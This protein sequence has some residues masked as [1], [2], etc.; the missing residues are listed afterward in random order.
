MG[1]EYMSTLCI[2]NAIDDKLLSSNYVNALSNAIWTPL[3]NIAY[4]ANKEI[5]IM[6]E[7]GLVINS[8]T[9][10]DPH[11]ISFSNDGFLYLTDFETGVYQS[12]DDGRSWRHIFRASNEWGSLVAFKV[13]D[14][15]KDYYWSMDKPRQSKASHTYYT[16]HIYE[17][18][19][20]SNTYMIQNKV[21]M[22]ERC[23]LH[24]ICNLLY[25]GEDNVF[26]FNHNDY[27]MLLFSVNGQK[28]KELRSL[29]VHK[30]N[31]IQ[32]GNLAID[33]Q[34]KMLYIGLRYGTVDVYNMT[35]EN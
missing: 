5:I 14:N 26:M 29:N 6:S 31:T 4:L 19:E 16:L 11:H 33:K 17:K 8:T 12:T 9:M 24:F 28:R 23:W 27:I 34:K 13:N 20:A 18:S 7:N 2:Y 21:D 32:Y 35:Y 15:K 22:P 1:G 30:Y 10:S 3:G 25:D